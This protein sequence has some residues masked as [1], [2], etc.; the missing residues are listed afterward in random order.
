MSLQPSLNK[1]QPQWLSLNSQNTIN[2]SM[3]HIIFTFWPH[4]CPS[5]HLRGQL[6]FILESQIKCVI[7]EASFDHLIKIQTLFPTQ[8]HHSQNRK[9]F[10]FFLQSTYSTFF[11]C[12][13]LGILGEIKTISVSFK[14][15]V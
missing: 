5:P 11:I 10:F 3:P 12:I 15:A 13:I 14:M 4:P 2:S 1:L 8:L 6:I 9:L 7:R